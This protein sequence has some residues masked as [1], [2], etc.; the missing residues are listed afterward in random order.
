MITL[1]IVSIMLAASAPLISR[2]MKSGFDISALESRIEILERS[3][4]IPS[5]TIMLWGEQSDC[6]EGWSVVNESNS[7]LDSSACITRCNGLDPTKYCV[8]KTG[9][10]STSSEVA[11]CVSTY[12]TNCQSSCSTPNGNSLRITTSTDE[13]GKTLAPALPNIYGKFSGSGGSGSTSNYPVYGGAI[14]FLSYS[15][16][17]VKNDGDPDAVF[18]FKAN[19]GN[20]IYNDSYAEVRPKS[21]SYMLCKKD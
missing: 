8:Y 5:G 6:P 15:G 7:T 12:K 11:T 20:P 18:S 1:L 16:P 21:I 2:K 10:V 9:K 17:K 14:Q 13:I 3:Q 19:Y 4:A